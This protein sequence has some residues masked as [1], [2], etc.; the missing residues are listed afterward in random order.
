[1][2]AGYRRRL[3][4]FAAASTVIVAAALFFALS[5]RSPGED[6]DRSDRSAPPAAV[7]PASRVAQQRQRTIDAAAALEAREEDL[8]RGGRVAPALASEEAAIGAAARRFLGVFLRYEVGELTRRTERQLRATTTESFGAQ[9][10]GAAPRP[11]A[12][13]AILAR[14]R[15]VSLEVLLEDGG[16]RA[17]VDGT[18]L[19]G[20]R[21]EPFSFR[22]ERRGLTWVAAGLAQ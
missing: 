8:P 20:G 6:G 9:L 22:F 7:S 12:T 14:A 15:L 4:A 3:V 21:R 18:A 16:L 13:R 11:T 19:R 17:I 10:L 5:H 2:D 1:M